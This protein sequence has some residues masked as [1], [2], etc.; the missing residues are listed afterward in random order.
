LANLD[1]LA[2]QIILED[3]K[4]IANSVNNPIALILSSQQLYEVEKISDKVIFLKNGKYIESTTEAVNEEK[5]L[6]IEMDSSATREELLEVF[7]P[8]ALEKLTFNGGI[9]TVYFNTSTRF[10]EVIVALGSADINLIYIRDI[11]ASTRRFFVN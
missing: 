9:Y 7:T 10:S 8:F 11:S 3:L 2:Q 6:I 5:P 1:V 4:A